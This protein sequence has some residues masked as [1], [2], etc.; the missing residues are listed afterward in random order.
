VESAIRRGTD[1][2]I[3]SLPSALA[4]TEVGTDPPFARR[5]QL[6]LPYVSITSPMIRTAEDNRPEIALV[7]NFELRP[8][9]KRSRFTEPGARPNVVESAAFR[10]AFTPAANA[11]CKLHRIMSGAGNEHAANPLPSFRNMTRNAENL[12][13][14]VYQWPFFQRF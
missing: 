4:V 11:A 3:P 5:V 12:I 6:C 14:L 1:P 7:P 13:L 8:G 10:I 2:R 9:D